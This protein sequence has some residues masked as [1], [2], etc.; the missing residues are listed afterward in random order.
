M[1]M[2]RGQ[3]FWEKWE[4]AILERDYTARGWRFIHAELP[5]RSKGAITARAN[6]LGLR[7]TKERQRRKPTRPT[8]SPVLTFWT[9]DALQACQRLR[10]WPGPVSPNLG[11]GP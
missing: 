6:A 3:P 4:D 7:G 9:P 10:D 11:L 5:H 8:A 2:N 1:K